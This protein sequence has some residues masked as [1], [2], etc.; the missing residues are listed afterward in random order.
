M[1]LW[2]TTARI[3]KSIMIFLNEQDINPLIAIIFFFLDLTVR[4]RLD[5]LDGAGATAWADGSVL[6]PVVEG[7]FEGLKGKQ[8]EGIYETGRGA[9]ELVGILKSFSKAELEMMLILLLELYSK[10]YQNDPLV[11]KHHLSEHARELYLA[12]QDFRV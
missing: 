5:R 12:I 6:H 4:M 11:V 3:Y 2:L 1:Y 10:A 9:N 8:R 7:F